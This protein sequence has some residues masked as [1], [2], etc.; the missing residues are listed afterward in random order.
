MCGV[1]VYKYA[2]NCIDIPLLPLLQRDVGEFPEGAAMLVGVGIDET[3]LVYWEAMGSVHGQPAGRA[4]REPASVGTLNH[5]VIPSGVG[6]CRHFRA[7]Y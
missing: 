3:A 5:Q 2:F 1:F 4:A 7:T 6:H